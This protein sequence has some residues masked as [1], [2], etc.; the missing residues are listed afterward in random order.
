MSPAKPSD[1]LFGI[2][3]APDTT[4]SNQFSFGPF[5]LKENGD[6]GLSISLGGYVILGGK[7]S[8]GI[9]ISDLI[10]RFSD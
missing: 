2:F 4:H 9:N 3:T 7:F 8:M 5:S 10:E 6:M 1:D